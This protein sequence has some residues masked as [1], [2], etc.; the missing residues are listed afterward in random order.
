MGLYKRGRTWWMRFR[1]NGEL[2]RRSCETSSKKL[3]EKIHAKVLS[4]IAEGKWLDI[5]PNIDRTFSELSDKYYKEYSP[6]KAKTTYVR[7]KSLFDHL[8][9]YFGDYKLV[10]ITPKIISAYKELRR[11]EGASP[12]TVNHELSLM[13]HAFNMAMKE[14]E[15]AKSNPVCL[16]SKEREDNFIERWLSLEEEELLLEVSADWLKEIIIF[17][18]NTGLRMSEILNLEWKRVNLFRK[19]ISIYEQKNRGRDTLPLNARTLEV[20]IARNKVRSIKNNL[21]FFSEAG[22][23]LDASNLRRAFNEAIDKAGI[24]RLRFHDLRHTFATRLIQN[25]VDIYTVQKLGRWRSIQMVERY[26]H[27]YTESLRGGIE[28]LDD[29]YEKSEHKMCTI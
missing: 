28:M 17:A 11:S 29:V 18:I 6:K 10:E 9:S 16:V 22:T 23:R 3:A 27:H 12:K 25:G 20:L 15:W 19:T 5:D 24:E 13:K 14:W 21:V 1:H 26:A 2:I 4:Q 8:N 7:D